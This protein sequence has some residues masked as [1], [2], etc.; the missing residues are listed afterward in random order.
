MTRNLVKHVKKLDNTQQ[1]RSTRENFAMSNGKD[2][3]SAKRQEEKTVF[4]SIGEEHEWTRKRT[5][6]N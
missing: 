1:L 4:A 3:S 2:R 5:R 6:L